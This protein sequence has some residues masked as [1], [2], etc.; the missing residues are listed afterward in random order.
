[1][2]SKDVTDKI[3]ESYKTL[4]DQLPGFIP[5]RA[6]N[7]LVAE[8][9]KS[10]AGEYSDTHKMI[11][12]EAGT[13]IGKSLAY[14]LS[15]IPFAK[16][17]NKKVVISTATVALQEQL[18]HKDLP[19][20]RRISPLA[21]SFIIA[22]GRQRYCC[23]HK[24]SLLVETN[25]V[26]DKQTA[27]FAH[28]PKSKDIDLL[29]RMY[30]ALAEKKWDGD[31]DSW[32]STIPN[33]I[34]QNIVS[35]KY[36]CH[37]GLP[38]HRDCPF[39]KARENLDKADVVIA[40]HSL[41]MADI[42]LGGGVVLSEPED[43]IYI[44]DEAH[45]LPSVARDHSSAAANLK[46]TVSWL[47]TL[48]KSV[49]KFCNLAEK[50]RVTRFQNTLNDNLYQ[51]IPA[52]NQLN[53]QFDPTL[54]SNDG[55]YRFQHGE[56]PEW[57]TEQSKDLKEISNKAN[58]ALAKISELVAERLK[59][60]QLSSV[61]AEPALAEM[62]FYLQRLENLAKVWNLMAQPNSDKGAPLAR[63]LEHS[64]D[65]D[66][67]ISVNVS[68]LEI[69]WQLDNNLW[70]RAAGAVIVSATMRALNNFSF[71]C[72]QAGISEKPEDGV[73]FLSLASPFN[74]QENAEL[75]IPKLSLEPS[76]PEFTELLIEKL[77]V[78]LADQKS[79]LVLFSSY[80][81]M[82]KV[83]EAIEKIAKKN[84]WSLLIQGQESRQEILKKHQQLCQ[85]NKI[86]ILFGTGSFSE[87]LD[88]PGNLLTNL[89]ITKIPFAVPSSPVEEAHSEY[90]ESKGG[91]PFMQISVPEASKK[92]IQSVGRLLRKEEDSGR[93]VL[94]DRRVITKRYGKALLDALPPFK[95]VID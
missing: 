38:M 32:P 19:F 77:P 9:A 70:S 73:R 89:I 51:L 26:D 54:F 93:V 22:K 59:E 62:G 39:Q 79:S 45:H 52:L 60:G 57:L 33:E 10:L 18:A 63:W 86:S 37:K 42:D 53:K 20:Y 85:S 71:F 40:N 12:A 21:F 88:L 4:Q 14:L 69:G 58:Q 41:V 34:W 74:Y 2:L 15:A 1:M 13:G 30:Q 66:G 11:V 55:I 3:R 16:L 92:L 91:N 6:Q 87:G 95:R 67:D 75:W 29:K 49:S 90:I 56:L 94:L 27:L 43:T 7:Y 28:K 80:W 36:S 23:A 83:A 5:R 64:K 68:P 24:L 84:G 8:I 44:F 81:Q 31:I 35:D 50:Q 76:A 17:N 61:M 82:N 78:Y 48:N 65:R 47:E 46:G 72:R 25:H